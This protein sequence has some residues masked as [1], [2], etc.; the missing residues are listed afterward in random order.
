MAIGRH[1]TA[2]HG[3]FKGVIDEIK[4]YKT[5]APPPG[6]VVDSEKEEAVAPVPDKYK[7]EVV[8][9]GLLHKDAG[10]TAWYASP[11]ILVFEKQD[12]TNKRLNDIHIR[13][14][15]GEKEPFQ[16]VFK[17]TRP[18]ANLSLRFSDLTGKAGRLP[19]RDI[20][21]NPVFAVTVIE[22][23]TE[24]KYPDALTRD[25]SFGCSP[26]LNRSVWVTVSTDKR[27]PPGEYAGAIAVME[28]GRKLFDLPLRVEVMNFTLPSEIRPSIQMN[29]FPPS[30]FRAA[31]KYGNRDPM[32]LMREHLQDIKEH[33][34]NDLAQFAPL[35]EDIDFHGDGLHVSEEDYEEV[36]S[37][38]ENYGKFRELCKRLVDLS[39]T[40]AKVRYGKRKLK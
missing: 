25:D 24:K 5:L 17:S 2:K 7:S 36:K 32:E 1:A 4:F 18:Y 22:N 12:L 27:T 11:D 38:V 10:L 34:V 26:G 8:L 37:Q 13:M 40:H 14:A 31:G 19:V 30:L 33:G 29:F 20:V 23:G 9:E 16:L 28:N 15:R 6:V 35:T 21:Y 39:L 3:Y